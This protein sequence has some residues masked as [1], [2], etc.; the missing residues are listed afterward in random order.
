MCHLLSMRTDRTRKA[1]RKA[2]SSYEIID[3]STVNFY[4]ETS[5][6]NRILSQT[7][8][9][10]SQFPFAFASSLVDRLAN[11]REGDSERERDTFDTWQ[12]LHLHAD[13]EQN[14]FIKIQFRDAYRRDHGPDRD[15]NGSSDNTNNTQSI[16]RP[17]RAD[18]NGHQRK[19]K[20][21][22]QT[23]S[24]GSRIRHTRISSRGLHCRASQTRYGQIR[25]AESR[26]LRGNTPCHRVNDKQRS[27]AR[28][29]SVK[30]KIE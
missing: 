11:A 3:D 26:Q 5:K 18:S 6:K 23:K 25:E 7:D 28:F 15:G 4:M 19:R 2:T 12:N 21:A 8:P 27:N 30:A 14:L 13:L 20:K 16:Q 17:N 1:T 9:S 22:T 29:T 24:I 10:F